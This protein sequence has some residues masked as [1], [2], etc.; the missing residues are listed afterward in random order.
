[1]VKILL[2]D[3]EGISIADTSF[4]ISYYI[5]DISITVHRNCSDAIQAFRNEA[6]DLIIT[7]IQLP[8][9]EYQFAKE[10]QDLRYGLDIL[11]IIRQELPNQKVICLSIHHK[12]TL[13]DVCNMNVHHVCKTVDGAFDELINLIKLLV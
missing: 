10:R 7:D 8:K 5:K 11:A 1:M 9:G 4:Y 13:G 12:E 2:I 3:D 6:F